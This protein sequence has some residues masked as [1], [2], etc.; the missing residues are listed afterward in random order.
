M[1][2]STR[3]SRSFPGVQLP[4][5]DGAG[6]IEVTLIAQLG[7]GAGD[8]LVKD[9]GER[10]RHHPAFIDALDE[11]SARLGG[12]HLQHGDA[13]SLYSFVVGA[14]GHP[15]HRHAGPRMFTAIAGSAGAE[16]RFATASDAQIATDPASFQRSLR[17]IRVPPDCLFTVRFGGGT[18]HQF[19]SS[20]RAH[21]AL[22][23]LSCHSNELAG[24][25]SDATRA[26]VQANQA[27]IPS[28]TDVL[29]QACWPSAATLASAPLLQLSLQAAPPS[30]CARLC[31]QTRALL[32]PLRRINLRPLRGFVERS[33]PRYPVQH[34]AA[35]TQGMLYRALPHSDYH[36]LTVL[37]LRPEQCAGRSASAL[38]A[39]VLDGFL[40]NPPGG[41]GQLMALRNRLVAPLRL[42][43]SP[44]G[45]PVSSLLSADRS[46]L[47][48]GRFPVL[49]ATVDAQD[50]SA[51]VLLGADDRHLRFRSSV[52]VQLADDGSVQISLGSRV[53]T[54]NRFGRLYM[55][56]IDAVH[57]HYI[58]PA[59]LRRAV[60]HALAPELA[61]WV[62]DGA[63]V[64]G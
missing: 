30:V 51:E 14:G 6:P 33:T 61:D 43:T 54:H 28:L 46:R 15:F 24:A 21:P 8:A 62:D 45:C 64:A 44:L 22:F 47:F 10:Q 48:A 40:R 23:A 20:H 59:L 50:R 55:A 7:I 26:Q 34:A 29:P 37:Q 27:D 53:Q 5:Q 52:R 32:G 16:L 56:M 31:A 11:P 36:D 60:E 18:W 25:M 1:P 38:L 63:P 4:A 13:S 41:V 2:G 12:M 42:R 35:A 58:A 3:N 9:A 39:D 19:A 57:R 49:D 17:R